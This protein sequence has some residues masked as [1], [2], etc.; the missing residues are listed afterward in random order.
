MRA[1][2]CLKQRGVSNSHGARAMHRRRSPWLFLPTRRVPQLSDRSWH[3]AGSQVL[4]EDFNYEL[5]LRL[6][7]RI[8]ELC[9]SAGLFCAASICIYASAFVFLPLLGGKGEVG[10]VLSY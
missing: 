9:S 4:Y 3:G 7:P 8:S 10:L 1:A 2:L 6:G 5:P